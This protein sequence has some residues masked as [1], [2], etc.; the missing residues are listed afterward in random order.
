MQRSTLRS[1]PCDL[2]PCQDRHRGHM[3]SLGNLEGSPNRHHSRGRQRC[4]RPTRI[5]QPSLPIYIGGLLIIS[6]DL[7]VTFRRQ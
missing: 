3:F 7:T 6:G 5:E 1:W 2:A 4:S